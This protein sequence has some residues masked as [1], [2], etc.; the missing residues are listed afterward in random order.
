MQS[1]CISRRSRLSLPSRMTGL[2]LVE[3]MVVIVILGILAALI[4][5]NVVDKPDQARIAAARQDIASLGEALRLY[6]V[7]NRQYP[8]TQQGLNAL[9]TKPTTPP[10]P[11]TY[12]NTGYLMK[13]PND[14]W[15]NP[16]M[17]L[18][19]GKFGE[20]DVWSY[21]SDGEPG[22]EGNDSDIG[23]WMN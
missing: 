6:K 14:P 8:T 22:G 13:L 16:Y 9:I 5:P 3:I 10:L 7:D 23:S 11:P 20:Y 21:G 15:G 2:T 18:S 12:P 4:V 1:R 19:P 17:Y